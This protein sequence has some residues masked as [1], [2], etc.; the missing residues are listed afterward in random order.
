MVVDA[1]DATYILLA[2]TN[3]Q[4]WI[5]RFL[6]RYTM[7]RWLLEHDAEAEFQKLKSKESER[8]PPT[9]DAALAEPETQI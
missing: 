1:L 2:G 3:E 4:E 7:N 9:P 8:M 5:R 6:E